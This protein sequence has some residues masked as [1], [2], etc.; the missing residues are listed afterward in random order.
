MNI[1]M[2]KGL[3]RGD[4]RDRLREITDLALRHASNSLPHPNEH[5]TLKEARKRHS[6]D[7]AKEVG[8]SIRSLDHGE[9]ILRTVANS[10]VWTAYGARRWIV[11]RLWAG[12]QP[13]P[14]SSINP[15]TFRFVDSI[16][17]SPDAVAL[18]ADITSSVD[19]GDVI[20]ASLDPEHP[21]P[22]VV[23]LKG[24]PMNDRIVSL[25]DEYGANL[26]RM[27]PQALDEIGPHGR[28]H[29]ERVARQERRA[30]NFESFAN[31]DIGIDPE[32]GGAG[33]Q[34]RS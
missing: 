26:E 11:R 13:V 30:K 25:V 21:G 4:F 5:S 23:E 17:S 18:V 34:C 6:Q 20:V 1:T 7:V 24:G 31:N 22:Y 14:I 16:N 10:M 28:K 29:F 33:P 12:G 19:I 8:V 3:A 27:P 32:T 15:S 9:A 2:T